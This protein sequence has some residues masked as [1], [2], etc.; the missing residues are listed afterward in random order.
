MII[1]NSEIGRCTDNSLSGYYSKKDTRINYTR[2][3]YLTVL[4]A[5][6]LI[7]L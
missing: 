6:N 3:N 1:R 2:P 4:H 5:S 7:L